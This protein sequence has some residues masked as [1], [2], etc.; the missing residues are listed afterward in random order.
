MY[1]HMYRIEYFYSRQNG[2]ISNWKIEDWNKICEKYLS[3][4]NFEKIFLYIK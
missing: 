1:I 2:M 4:V 3:Y